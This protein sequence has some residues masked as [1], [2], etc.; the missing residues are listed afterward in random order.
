MEDDK[1]L[2]I[3]VRRETLGTYECLASENGYQQ[4]VAL[5]NLRAPNILN[6]IGDDSIA[7]EGLQHRAVPVGEPRSYW[8]QFVTVTVLLSMTLAIAVALAFFTYHDKLKAKSKVQGCSSPQVNKTSGQEKVPLNS[9]QNPPQGIEYQPIQGAFQE[10]ADSA[11]SCCVEVEG[12]YQAID[13]DNNRLKS[14]L[15]NRDDSKGAMAAQAV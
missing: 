14:G 8:V 7:E 2:V 10:A 5:Y 15:A 6:G 4:V 12:A 3:V 13:A 9:G 1:A 11:K